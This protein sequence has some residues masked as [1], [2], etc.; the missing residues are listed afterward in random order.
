M[1]TSLALAPVLTMRW[2]GDAAYTSPPWIL[3]AAGCNADGSRCYDNHEGYDILLYYKPVVASA[4]GTIQ[5]AGWH[6][7]SHDTLL[8]LMVRMDHGNN[9][10]TIYGHLSMV[11]YQSGSTGIGRWQ[12]GTSGAT[13]GV[14]GP[15][16]HFGVERWYNNAWRFTDPYG[17]RDRYNNNDNGDDPWAPPNRA[18]GVISTWL[19]VDNPLQSAPP[20]GDIYHLD[21]GQSGF[22]ASCASGQPYW[23]TVSDSSGYLGNLMWTWANGSTTDCS[24]FWQISFP[25]TGEYEV[26]VHIPTWSTT[27]RSHSVRYTIW[28]A[29]YANPTLGTSTTVVVDQHRVGSSTWI[30][31]GRYNFRQGTNWNGSVT[32]VDAS[33]IGSDVDPTSRRVLVDGMRWVKTH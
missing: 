18:D 10:Q 23:N 3:T 32:V 13:G 22:T 17:W 5:Y 29:N 24:A 25:S 21:N 20:R 33:Y 2:Q 4:A 31:L 12:I 1:A 28:S 14:T 30:S 11:R 15:H 19:W 7:T 6:T 27:Q 8:G 26:E 9:Y 16:L